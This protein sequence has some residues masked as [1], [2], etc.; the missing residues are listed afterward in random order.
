LAIFFA[1]VSLFAL[2]F[3][4]LAQKVNQ[5][6]NARNTVFIEIGGNAGQY[7]FNYGRI[8]YQKEAF[9]LTATS[10]FSLWAEKIDGS[11]VWNPA[12]PLELTSL[13]GRNRHHLELGFGITP[14]L[15]AEIIS[16][17]ES[18]ELVQTKGSRDLGAILPFRIGYRYQKPEQGFFFRLGYTPFFKFTGNSEENITFQP[19]HAGIGLGW[20]F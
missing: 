3:Q 16:S 18:G 1:S 6:S 7:A 15:E 9:K 10:G 4:L 17:F 20:S 14:F 8:F 12:L 5:S 19:V 2:P 11:T 13:L